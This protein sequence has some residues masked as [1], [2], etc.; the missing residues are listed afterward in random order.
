MNRRQ[1]NLGLISAASTAALAG[2]GLSTPALGQSKVVVTFAAAIFTEAGRAERM[3]AIVDKFNASQ[4]KI[5]VQPVAMTFATMANTVFTQM[6]GGGG[7]DVIRFDYIDFYAAVAAKRIIQLDDYIKDSDYRFRAPDKGLKVDGK[8]YGVIFDTTG[9]ALLYN[10]TLLPGGVPP[11]TFEEFVSTAKT[12][13]K[14]GTFGFAFRATMAERAGFWQD[15]CNF[16]YG[17]GGRWSDDQGKLTINSAKV[18]EGIRAYKTVYDA[19]A[20]PKGADAATYRRMFWEGKLAME[21]DNGGVAAIFNQQAPN[22]PL[23]AAFSPFPSRDQGLI[24]TAL[25]I[26]ANTKVKDASITFTKWLLQ[27]ENQKLI[28]DAL[29]TNSGVEVERTADERARQPWLEV[30]DAQSAHSVSQLVTG[31]EVKTPEIQQIVLEHVLK[32]LQGGVDAQKAMDEAQRIVERR[33]LRQ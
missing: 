4:D 19:G 16:V 2:T 31:H 33:I 11:K 9:Y 14:D 1:V 30:Y 3:R 8:R 7:P 18:V 17:F 6:G 32:V 12:V 25:A 23:K 20:I 28:Q 10:P 13:T 24:L 5:E 29:G 26:N 21:V 15:V 27:P 22:L